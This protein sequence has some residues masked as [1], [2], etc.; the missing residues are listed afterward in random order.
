MCPQPTLPGFTPTY[1]S[2]LTLPGYLVDVLALPQP[3]LPG[4]YLVDVGPQPTLPGFT[5]T[6]PS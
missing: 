5:P 1:P 3:T 6:Y 4:W 2:W